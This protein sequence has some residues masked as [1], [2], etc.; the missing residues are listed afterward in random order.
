MVPSNSTWASKL[1]YGGNLPH[2]T[3][4]NGYMHITCG[5]CTQELV[6]SVKPARCAPV[7]AV[8][9]QGTTVS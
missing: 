5:G 8:P 2:N 3:C 9:M 7:V 1:Y 6:E 4:K